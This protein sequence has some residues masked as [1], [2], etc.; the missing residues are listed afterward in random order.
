[1]NSDKI[2]KLLHLGQSIPHHPVSR[3]IGKLAANEFPPL[4]NLLINSFIK[5]YKVNMAEAA[6][7]DPTRYRNFNAFFTRPLA[8]GARPIV[9]SEDT[10]VSPA[11]GQV[12]QFGNIDNGQLIQAKG[13]VFTVKALLGH[14]DANT[15]PLPRFHP[16]Y[17]AHFKRGKFATIYLSPRDY[18]RVHMPLKGQL[19]DTVY[20]PGKLFSVNMRT[21]RMEE[22]LFARN[23]RLVCYFDTEI[24]KMALILVGAMIVASM[25]TAW[26][27]VI[28]P[29]STVVHTRYKPGA[30]ELNKGDEM[31]RFQLGSTVILLFPAQSV[32]FDPSMQLDAKIKMGEALA[33]LCPNN[34]YTTPVPPK[35][36]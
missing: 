18:H 3:A 32:R 11:D 6:I 28:S 16:D 12:S 7:P 23:E 33:Y 21:T 10:L 19:T 26:G 29:Q 30:V 34:Q 36:Q 25:A 27:G 5:A 24:G 17:S 1:M 4:K 35:P 9:H 14:G 8:I 20:I 13:K 31:G 2:D 22:Q 15:A